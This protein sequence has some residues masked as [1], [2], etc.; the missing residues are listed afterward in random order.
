MEARGRIVTSLKHARESFA[1]MD[2]AP[3]K[4]DW[5]GWLSTVPGIPAGWGK[6]PADLPVTAVSAPTPPRARTAARAIET[7]ELPKA[8]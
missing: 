2:K 1:L 8:A 4:F 6:S 3:A 5:I 7:V